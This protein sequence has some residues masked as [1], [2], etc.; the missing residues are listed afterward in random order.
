MLASRAALTLDWNQVHPCYI[1]PSRTLIFPKFSFIFVFTIMHYRSIEAGVLVCETYWFRKGKRVKALLWKS[2]GFVGLSLPLTVCTASAQTSTD[3]VEILVK[4]AWVFSWA[5]G[6]DVSICQPAQ[7]VCHTGRMPSGLGEISAVVEGNLVSRVRSSW[8][9]LAR[10]QSAVCAFPVES[11][12]V[13]CVRVGASLVDTTVNYL[14]PK[15]AGRRGI[16]VYVAKP[17]ATLSRAA[18][19][20]MVKNFSVEL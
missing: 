2:I 4:P 3:V 20:A 10:K 14:E 18:Q 5:G 7:G 9:A 17:S 11:Q 16:L 6:S 13:I 19:N 1:A 15:G 8:I 12:E